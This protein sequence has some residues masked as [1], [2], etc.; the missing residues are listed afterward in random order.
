MRSIVRRVQQRPKGG[1]EQHQDDDA[2]L[3]RCFIRL[4]QS[5]LPQ[6]QLQ[7]PAWQ[8]RHRI[9]RIDDSRWIRRK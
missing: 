2:S 4:S 9:S 8:L 3:A 5:P 6:L 1:S 7:A